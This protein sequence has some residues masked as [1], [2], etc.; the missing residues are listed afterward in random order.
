MVIHSDTTET[1][2]QVRGWRLRR[3]KK[4]L[5]PQQTGG[6]KIRVLSSPFLGKPPY[7]KSLYFEVVEK[8]TPL[9]QR[10]TY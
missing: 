6:D 9:E 4:G 8:A 5:F 2:E 7:P 1:V 3:G 10:S